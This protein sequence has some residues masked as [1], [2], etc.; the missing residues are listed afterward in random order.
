MTPTP[1]ACAM[2]MAICDSV[3][4][5]IAEAIIGI[6]SLMLRVMR[7]RMS[8]SEGKTSDRLGLSS[9]SSKVRPSRGLSLSIRQLR[10]RPHGLRALPR[11]REAGWKEEFARA[12]PSPYPPFLRL[13]GPLGLAAA[14]STPAPMC[15]DGGARLGPPVHSRVHW[16]RRENESKAGMGAAALP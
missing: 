3:T 9:T 5:S 1:P 15:I 16:P 10:L 6:L 13:N 8:T 12:G 7:E 11:G 4:V 2:A 14:S